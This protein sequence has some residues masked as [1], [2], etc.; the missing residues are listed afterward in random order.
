MVKSS[1]KTRA[2]SPSSLERVKRRFVAR[3]MP[4]FSVTIPSPLLKKKIHHRGT[5]DTE[6]DGEKIF[7]DRIDRIYRIE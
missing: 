5:E 1:S 2:G 4:S 3:R 6:K 7:F